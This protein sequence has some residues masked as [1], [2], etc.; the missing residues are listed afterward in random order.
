MTEPRPYRPAR[1]A[2]EAAAELCA[3]AE[4]G[5]LDGATVDA[6]LAVAGQR[7]AGRRL[8]VPCGLTPREVETLGLVARGLS[9]RQIARAL[10]IA[11]KTVDGHIQRIYAKIGV[12]TRVGATLFAMSHD[13]VPAL[14]HYG[15]NSP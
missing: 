8:T 5:R 12:S 11:P 2:A 3:Q 14:R 10:S 6:V 1:S 4:Q 13:L 7:A 9:I 15:E